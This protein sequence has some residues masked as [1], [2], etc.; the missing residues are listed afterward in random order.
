MDDFDMLLFS[1]FVCQTNYRI[2]RTQMRILLLSAYDGGSH[3]YWRKGLVA[4]FSE[5]QWTVLTLP[6]RHFSWRIRGNPISWLMTES[7]KLSK[8]YDLIIATSMVDLSTL[9]GIFP[10]LAAAPTIC[11]F[12][13]NQFA[14]PNQPQPQPQPQRGTVLE[15]KM[16]NIYAALSA[17]RLLFN[18]EFNRQTFLTGA[19]QL[20]KRMPDLRP[21][22]ISEWLEDK[23]AVLPVAVEESA[24]GDSDQR[25]N[26]SPI[27]DS[28]HRWQCEPNESPIKIVWAARWE[29]DKGPDQLLTIV[30]ELNR[31]DV[32]YRLCLLGETFR[33]VPEEF[34]AIR[35]EA[36]VRIV[37]YGYAESREEYLEWLRTAEIFLSTALHEFQGVSVLEG[38]LAGCKPV[39]PDRLSYSELV[40]ANY[41]YASHPSAIEEE[42]VTAV[43]LIIRLSG[44]ETE[45]PDVS[46]FTW[47]FLE[48]SYREELESTAM[49]PERSVAIDKN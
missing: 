3:S 10:G 45:I 35:E 23:S 21:P 5:Y 41:L 7:E 31:R 9:K 49:F 30:R 34:D 44:E 1:L 25:R 48:K 12:H 38:V 37:Q 33:K 43:D 2:L 11:Y 18:S 22:R 47:P 40:P 29:H 20:I 36:G 28:D 17:D 16:V 6:G 27:S 24:Y 13:E 15:P 19:D 4:Q 46:R 14:Y 26:S 8:N 39:L 42:A 32:D